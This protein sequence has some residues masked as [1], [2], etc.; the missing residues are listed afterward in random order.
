DKIGAIETPDARMHIGVHPNRI[1]RARLDT[2][3]TVDA[4][5][6]IDLIAHGIFLD[7]GVW[8]LPGF[9]MDTV[10]RA[11]SRAQE[12]RRAADR[13]VFFQGQTMTAA[14]GIG[15]P[16]TLFRILRRVS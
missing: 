7:I 14:I 2:H 11:R 4:T 6:R 1:T 9:D 8:M 16:L 12:T 15:V 3:T 10:R 5:Q 13:A